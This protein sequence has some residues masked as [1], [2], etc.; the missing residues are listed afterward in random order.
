[1]RLF[2]VAA[3]V[4]IVFAVIATANATQ[5]LFGILWTS[6]LCG[7]LLAYFTDHLVP[8]VVSGAGFT[9]RTPEA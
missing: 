3:V 2:L 7:A 6:W 5:E 8:W 9:R 1:M 4:L